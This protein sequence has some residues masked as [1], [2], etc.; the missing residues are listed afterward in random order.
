[1]KAK[2][3]QEKQPSYQIRRKTYATGRVHFWADYYM[4]GFSKFET[5]AAHGFDTQKEAAEAIQQ[6]KNQFVFKEEVV[7]AE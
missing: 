2:Q 1:M 3:A 6:H 7:W 5:L 4:K